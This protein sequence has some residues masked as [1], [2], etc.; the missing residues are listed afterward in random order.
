[1]SRDLRPILLVDDN[2]NDIELTLTAFQEA[3]LANP[4]EVRRDGA[5]ALEYLRLAT[6]KP[7]VIL[8]DLKMPKV[9]GREVLRQIKN[10]AEL[11][12]VPVV[13]LTSSR[14]DSDLLQSYDLGAN[15]FVVK[16]VDFREFIQTVARVGCF[17]GLVN[18]PSP[19]V[20][21]QTR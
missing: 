12:T 1:M 10:T 20:S 8:L 19:L 18:E 6:T 4:V 3:G 17:W 14:Q 7:I 15:A 11:K 5:E 2:A 9:D 16:P 21:G 13:V